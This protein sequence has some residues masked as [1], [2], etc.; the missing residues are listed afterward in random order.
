MTLSARNILAL[1]WLHNAEKDTDGQQYHN[2][3]G[4]NRMDTGGTGDVLSGNNGSYQ[5]QGLNPLHSAAAG[6]Y[7]HGLAGDLA[8][9]ELGFRSMIAGDLIEYLPEAFSL[10][11][12]SENKLS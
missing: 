6:V 3:T 8:A 10:L 5:A 2:P 7:I 4:N 11:E 9:D 1:F 12:I